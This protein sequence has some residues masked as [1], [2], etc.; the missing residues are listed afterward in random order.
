MRAQ[1]TPTRTAFI[2]LE[3]GERE[4][5]RL[6]F[7]EL[8]QRARRIALKLRTL[9]APGDRVVLLYPA[10]LEFICAFLGCLYAGV[11]AVPGY[12]PRQ[13]RSLKRLQAII[14][15]AAPALALTNT[16]TLAGLRR[17]SGGYSETLTLDFIATDREDED[18]EA[19]DWTEPDIG[20]DTLALLQYTSGSTGTPKG[21]MIS[22]GNILSNMTAIRA[23]MDHDETTVMLSWLPMFH[24]MGL[25]GK[26]LHPIYLGVQSVLMDPAAF[27]QRPVRWL[28][29]ISKYRATTSG[30]PDSAYDLCARKISNAEKA[31]LDLSSWRVAFNGAEPVRN[32][33]MA[34][35][36][37]AFAQCGFR[38]ESMYPTYGM[39]EATLFITG[40]QRELPIYVKPVDAD[41][42]EGGMVSYGSSIRKTRDLVSCGRAWKGHQIR[43]VNPETGIECA[44]GQ[45]G[46][47]WL[48]GPS[49]GC[50]YWNRSEESE[51]TFRGRLAN[52][53]A[54]YLRTGD[55]G[56]L[57]GEDLF[58]TGRLKDL[59]IIAGRNLYPQD[60][61]RTAEESDLAIVRNASAA[62]SIEAD[63]Q[64]RLVLICEIRRDALRSLNVTQV[65][66]SIRRAIAEVHEVELHAVALLKT[67]TIPRTSSGKIQRHRCR[68]A[69]LSG[70]DLEIVGEWH[71]EV[72]TPSVSG[73][74]NDIVSW[75]VQR[76]S[77]RAGIPAHQI[78][79]HEPFS[80]YG[81]GSVH[82]VEL[83]GE[84]QQWLGRPVPPTLFYDFPSI[85]RVASHLT[86][87]PQSAAPVY[88]APD[89]T[90]NAIAIIGLG[91]RFPGA[92][93]PEEF[94]SLLREAR[95]AVVAQKSRRAG[96]GRWGL[97]E[98][99][100]DFD[101][102][103][104]GISG[105]EAEVMD[106]Q[107]RLLLELA[108]ETIEHA[109]VPP[110]SLAGS[111]TAVV[112]GIS[113]ADYIRL[114]KDE[115][116]ETDPYTATGNALSVA[117]NRI[118]YLLD[119]RG[120]SWAV[121]TACSSSLVAVHQACETLRRG[122]C[123]AAL[124]GGVNLI[125]S[126]QLSSAFANAGMLSPDGQCKAFDAAANGYVRGE[127]GGMVLLKRLDDAVRDNDNILAVIRGSAVNQD[128]RSNGLTAPNGP[129]QQAVIRDALRAAGVNARDISYVEAHGTG[130]PLGDPIE[131]NSL[132]SVL[133]EDRR[134]EDHCWV[135]S[136]KTNIG[137]LEAAAGI[138]SLIKTV[139]AI[140]HREIPAHLHYRSL[141][142]RISMENTPF[143]IVD[144]T[145]TWTGIDG[146]RFAGLSSFG[147]GGTNA[148]VIL[149]EGPVQQLGTFPEEAAVNVVAFS[150]RT[151]HALRALA[152]LYAAYIETHPEI[153][154]QDF[155]YS[156]NT[157]RCHFAQRVAVTASNLE[158]LQSKLRA[159]AEGS[160]ATPE[161]DSRI[162]EYLSGS[163]I[164]WAALYRGH[165]RRRLPLPTYP[166]ER[167]RYWMNSTDTGTHPLLGRR[168]EQHA[169]QPA[170]CIWESHFDDS[171]AQFL[172]GHSILGSPVLPYSA[173][174]EMALSAASQMG[175][176]N[177]STVTGLTLHHP[178]FLPENQALTVQTVVSP[179]SS[180]QLSFAVYNKPDSEAKWQLC[181][182]AVI[183]EQSRN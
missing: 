154:L 10:S 61:E 57:D 43:I 160:P 50:G 91:C 178:L 137:H 35:F 113:N 30:A 103:F 133:N 78:D 54:A 9:T 110:R 98:R 140:Q 64:E 22:H 76:V 86:E 96:P 7:A 158:E 125:L 79:P 106:P 25:F 150:A 21:V 99:V 69:F 101:A 139:L 129:A 2:F 123:D 172:R 59:M 165:L 148:H 151:R 177:Y 92:G 6:T 65:V 134:P 170:T 28:Q 112:I 32:T 183:E 36:S 100:E 159:I 116:A 85:D 107:Q 145:T 108:W 56:F 60:L 48:S 49:V 117:A 93:N 126:P 146:S 88:A 72:S 124:A 17:R 73:E 23:A 20:P 149:G 104:F 180:G 71:K 97:L 176:E 105:R 12:P 152:G 70:T 62:F 119:L 142:P 3:N 77:Q 144:R 171:A 33:T 118:S 109:C 31:G 89:Q 63:G 75:L 166:F 34:R 55:L 38:P 167:R 83:S 19:A 24:D 175:S 27:V 173:Y 18:A 39:A 74:C 168:L 13:N 29:A 156:V 143:R 68:L 95:D 80:F 5:G 182:S 120:P 66:A 47:I 58:V 102:D 37:E 161:S 8:D 14:E 132:I 162:A 169:H 40:R 115:T 163:S 90:S 44:A 16:V 127:G 53:A 15:D 135:G 136:V 157:G 1:N 11:V 46:E 130:T 164:D 67:A 81:L 82:A 128:G 114:A 121:D 26:V 174:V 153:Q 45:I 41:A 138:A 131:L 147:F 94:W 181:A 155:G 122:E 87:S 52:D 4:S 42:L 84:L 179:Q 51:R 141:N 111:R